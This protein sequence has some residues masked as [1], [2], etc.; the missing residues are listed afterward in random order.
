MKNW[1]PALGALAL[2]LSLLL[3]TWS[4]RARAEVFPTVRVHS[5]P[6]SKTSSYRQVHRK[7]LSK[8][9]AS[10]FRRIPPSKSNPTQNKFNPPTYG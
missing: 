1:S 5:W 2:T 9:F 10:S 8:Q 3:L 6:S 7:N 4:T